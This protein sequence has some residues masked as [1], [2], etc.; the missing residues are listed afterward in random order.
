MLELLIGIIAMVAILVGIITFGEGGF[1]W[2][3]SMNE[4]AGLAWSQAISPNS[5]ATAQNSAPQAFIKD[6]DNDFY[7][8]SRRMQELGLDGVSYTVGDTQTQGS[9]AAFNA[10]A[11]QVLNQ[12]IAGNPYIEYQNYTAS[13]LRS[14]PV[15]AQALGQTDTSGWL[16][17]ES[18]PNTDRFAL[19]RIDRGNGMVVD[20]GSGLQALV[21]GP[22]T[23]LYLRSHVF[24]PPLS[25]LQ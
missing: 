4:A 12:S 18:T 6:W 10:T 24:L 23:L 16:I 22:T 5:A 21:Y 9:R 17:G 14:Q 3:S 2:L 1:H 11:Q 7:R 25:G 13:Y 8:N 20:F 15:F 19:G